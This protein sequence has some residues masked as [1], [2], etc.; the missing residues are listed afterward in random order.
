M[1]VPTIDSKDALDVAPQPIVVPTTG[2]V[3]FIKTM[4][5]GQPVPVAGDKF[6]QFH[7]PVSNQTGELAGWSWYE[8]EDP[9]EIE[10][11]REVV[12]TKL[13]LNVYEEPQKP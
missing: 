13:H 5:P 10:Q 9:E 12:A 6:I 2:K 4:G 3:R 11:L 7:R 1:P 8:T